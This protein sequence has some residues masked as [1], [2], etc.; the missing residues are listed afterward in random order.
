MT[1]FRVEGFYLTS[2]HAT[3]E[4]DTEKEAIEKAYG[5]DHNDDV[6]TEPSGPIRKAQWTATEE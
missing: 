4:A 6:D 3:V 1:T 5:G 2:M